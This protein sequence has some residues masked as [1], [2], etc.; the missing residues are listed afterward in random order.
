MATAHTTKRHR[1]TPAKVIS[2]GRGKLVVVSAATLICLYLCFRIAQPFLPALVW[3]VTGAVVTRPLARWLGRWIGPP[4]WRALATVSIVAIAVFAPLACLVYF[5]AAQVV[6]SVQSLQETDY[7][8]RWRALAAEHPQVTYVWNRVSQ[9]LDLEAAMTQLLE[10]IRGGALAVISG[11]AYTLA[12]ALLALFILFFLYRDEQH[13]L[14]S[15]RRLAPL[16]D[17]E[18]DGLLT[19]LGD[20]IHATIFGVV[21]VAVIQGTLG[22]IMFWIL[23]LPSPALWGTAMGV[24]AIVPYLGTFVVW[25][26]TALLLLLEGYWGSALALVTWGLLAI[27]LIDNLLYPFLVGNRLKQHTVVAFLAIVGGIAVFGASGIILGPIVVSLT[28]FLL[29]YWR[30][31]TAPAPTPASA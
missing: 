4:A 28:F 8:A 1:Q 27:G 13:V 11:S 14:T 18:T 29:E 10:A 24:L 30:R 17:S 16:S 5:V 2:R 22:G 6:D 12:Q 23:G 26:P 20:T 31:H 7:L 25:G 21:A 3:A 9:A 19:R 15:V